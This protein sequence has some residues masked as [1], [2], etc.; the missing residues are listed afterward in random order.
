MAVISII[1]SVLAFSISLLTY[2]QK[3]NFDKK[4]FKYIEENDKKKSLLAFKDE[5]NQFR[6]G[7]TEIISV[8]QEI[9][10]Q[11]KDNYL[12][13]IESKYSKEQ[14]LSF[15]DEK[16]YNTFLDLKVK[17]DDS[18]NEIIYQKKFDSAK[19]ALRYIRYFYN[20]LN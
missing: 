6:I 14:L 3:T 13:V 20:E 16:S 17:I 4:T 10:V 15:I 12:Y 1:L 18:L 8:N 11:D 9:N 2:I 7:I 5:L 19:D